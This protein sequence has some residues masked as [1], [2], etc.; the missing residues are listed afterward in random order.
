MGE[1]KKVIVIGGGPGGYVAAIRAAQLGA[2]V[3]LIEKEHLGGT[4]LNVGCIPTKALLHPAEIAASVREGVKF[5]IHATLESVNWTEVLNYKNDIVK[6][7]T[8]G[9]ASLLKANGVKVIDGTAAFVKPKTVEVKKADGTCEILEADRFIIATGSVPVM[10]PI[11]GLKES[12]FVVDST[13]LLS[14]ETLPAS[15][16]IIGGGVIGIEFACAMQSL[17][18]KVTIVEA[19]NRLVPTLD[20]EIA[21]QL[22]KY[23]P[24][25]GIEINLEHKVMAIAD[26]EN[27]A[28]ITVD[29]NGTEKKIVAE[30]ILCCVGRRAYNDGLNCEAGGIKT[31]RSKILVNENLETAV[32]GVYAIGDCVGQVMLAHTASA[33]GEIAAENCMGEHKINYR[34]EEVPS[35][36]Y[37]F[38]ETA[39]VGF[40]EEQLKENKTAYHVGRFPMSG[41]GRALIANNGDGMVKVLVGDAMGEVLGVHIIGPHATELIGEAALAIKMECTAE[42]IINLIH[43]HPTVS[44]S[45]REAFLASDNRAIHMPNKKK[46]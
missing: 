33:Q 13:G 10:P 40:T 15:L 21:K 1:Q 20:G 45:V 22:M 30:K 44:E 18:C 7:L 27:D 12:K 24:A 23:L 31:E 46:G 29:N 43:S 25:Q 9:V 35:C 28:E 8:G 11:P 16:A 34:P 6:T 19:L 32:P 4:C 17:G 3:T 26:R 36:V 39:G 42:E 14:M 5:G 2:A 38:P 41:N 37:S